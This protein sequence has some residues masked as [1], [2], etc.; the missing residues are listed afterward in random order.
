MSPSNVFKI[1]F[2]IIIH[3]RLGLPS[4]NFFRLLTKTLYSSPD[5]IRVISQKEWNWRGLW[6]VWG[7]VEMHTEF[8]W[9]SLRERDHLQDISIDRKMILKWNKWCTP[10]VT[11]IFLFYF[12]KCWHLVSAWLGHHQASIY[13]NLK[14]AC[15]YNSSISWDSIHLLCL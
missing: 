15:A 6:H 11:N 1:H 12:F 8:W 7:R 4:G 3:L 9:G 5:I 10:S 14:K 2:N 13:K